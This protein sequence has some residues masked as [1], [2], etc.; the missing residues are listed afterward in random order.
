MTTLADTPDWLA[1]WQASNRDKVEAGAKRAAQQ[2][3]LREVRAAQ[4]AARAASTPKREATPKPRTAAPQRAQAPKVEKV[5]P[6]GAKS[7]LHEPQGLGHDLE[8]PE[9]WAW[10]GGKRR[11]QVLD[12]N[13]WPP[14][15]VRKVG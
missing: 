5:K 15:V 3:A 4:R 11:E 12:H 2:A 7:R 1:N 8:E 9:A 13:Y 10:D 14:R 6:D